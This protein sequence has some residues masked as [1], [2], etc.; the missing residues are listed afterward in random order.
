L[1]FDGLAETEGALEPYSTKANRVKRSLVGVSEPAQRLEMI[2]SE[3]FAVVL[4]LK[5]PG[6]DFYLGFCCASVIGILKEL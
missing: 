4:K 1:K 2:V 3:V 5:N 6:L